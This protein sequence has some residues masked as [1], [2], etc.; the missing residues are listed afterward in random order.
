[1][2]H[3]LLKQLLQQNAPKASAGFTENFMQ[4]L[5]NRPAPL[6]LI[7]PKWV[8]AFITVYVALIV[9]IVLLGVLVSL[10]VVHFSFP[11]S[12][13]VHQWQNCLVFV[14]LFWLMYIGNYLIRGKYTSASMQK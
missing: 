13:T 7:A 10:P 11:N 9:V 4:Q 5:Q 8:R 14:V 2:N 12:V 6:P 3:L 1:M